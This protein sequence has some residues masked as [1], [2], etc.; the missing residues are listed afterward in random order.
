MQRLKILISFSVS[1]DEKLVNLIQEKVK[2]LE[3]LSVAVKQISCNFFFFSLVV[4]IVWNLGI[5]R[6]I[7]L[8]VYIFCS[9]YNSWC[10]QIRSGAKGV[11]PSRQK[12]NSKPI[13]RSHSSEGASQN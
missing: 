4:F 11:V 7:N 1:E 12:S 10:Y 6:G 9:D 8:P 5:W 13:K 3:R 2:F